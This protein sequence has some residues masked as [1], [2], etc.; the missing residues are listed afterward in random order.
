MH[1]YP[2]SS[3]YRYGRDFPYSWTWQRSM[4]GTKS[5]I[6]DSVWDFS[7][8]GNCSFYVVRIIDCLSDVFRENANQV[9]ACLIIK[10]LS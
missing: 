6:T 3:S 1:V 9:H 7:L 8:L 10:Q 5:D 4:S 2:F